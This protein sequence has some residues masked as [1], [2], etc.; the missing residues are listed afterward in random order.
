M[1]TSALV[2]AFDSSARVLGE[3]GCVESGQGL[4]R[5]GGFTL[6]ESGP[7][8]GQRVVVGKKPQTQAP[9]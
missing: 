8:Q 5:V 3:R 4:D 1:E 2:V 7:R 6:L 9:G